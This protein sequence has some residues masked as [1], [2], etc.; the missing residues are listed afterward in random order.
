[1]YSNPVDS[2]FAF[3]SYQM[4]ESQFKLCE[5]QGLWSKSTI[6]T[7][8]EVQPNTTVLVLVLVMISCYVGYLS[9]TEFQQY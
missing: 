8:D 6:F 2:P 3:L 7:K 4:T 9:S 5:R 1:M